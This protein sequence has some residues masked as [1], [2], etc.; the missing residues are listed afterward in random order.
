MPKLGGGFT[1]ISGTLFSDEEYAK[2]VA[3]EDLEFDVPEHADDEMIVAF[4]VSLDELN[5]FTVQT[6]EGDDNSA[7]V[8]A[9]IAIGVAGLIGGFFYFFVVAKRKKDEEE[10]EEETIDQE[11]VYY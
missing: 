11:D 8:Y 1:Y 4:I 5:K 6:V 2:L 9:F 7:I 3:G 10:E